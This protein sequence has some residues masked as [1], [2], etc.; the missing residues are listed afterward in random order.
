METRANYALIGVFTLAIAFAAFGFVYWFSGPS[1]IGRQE[2]Y[3]IVFSGA[4]SG[5]TR[6][7]GV[8]FNGVKVGEV[9]HLA[10]SESDPSKVDVEVKIDN[11]TPVKTDTR[12]RLE[13]RGFTGVADVLL[14][15]GTPRAPKLVAQPG[16]RYPQIQAE[17]SEIQNLLGNVQHLSTKAAEVLVKLDKLL[18]QNSDSITATL[19]NAETFTKTLAD[20]SSAVTA[21]M[22][23][24]A[25]VA[26]SLKPVAARLDKVLAAGEA[27]LKAI[28][29]RKIKEITG[30]I[31]GAS[32][33]INKFSATGLRQYEA[34]AVDGRKAVDTLDRTLRSIEK[35]PSQFIFG[36]SQTV[37]EYQGR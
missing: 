25:D 13:T 14:V 15:G 16:Q 21:F 30:N 35:D 31:A 29:P 24:A 17:R 8:L 26:H 20:N 32:A 22:R 1:Q 36:P 5:L 28:D 19:K 37:P 11:R 12:A 3:Q 18:D 34:L 33:N 2:T 10:I 9:T 27:R 23:D 7:S 6:G 4:V